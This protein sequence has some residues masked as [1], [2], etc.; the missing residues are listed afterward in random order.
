MSSQLARRLD[1][2]SEE[3]ARLREAIRRIGQ[4]FASNLDRPALLELALKTAVDAVQ[5]SAGRVS[6]R[7]TPDGPL[8]E[9]IREG[10]LT[11]LEAA[12]YEAERAALDER[13]SERGTRPTTSMPSRCRS[14]RSS[15]AAGSTV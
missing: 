5:A 1:E 8:A 9:A 11:G 13:R 14:G 3:R 7:G 15:Q 12:I 6:V 2:L 10:S 4:T